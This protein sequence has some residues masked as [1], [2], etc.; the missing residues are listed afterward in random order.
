MRLYLE[1]RAKE[2]LQSDYVSEDGDPVLE[3]LGDVLDIVTVWESRSGEEPEP[4]GWEIL[5]STGGPAA[6]LELERDGRATVWANWWSPTE[7][8]HGRLDW[9]AGYLEE[10]GL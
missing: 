1:G 5:L 9:L 8:V 6:G 2:G 3:Y 7:R 10:L 4:R